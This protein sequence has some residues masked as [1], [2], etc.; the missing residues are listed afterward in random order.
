[1]KIQVASVTFGFFEQINHFAD[2]YH[3]YSAL[4]NS[5]LRKHL[6]ELS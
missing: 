3:P 5:F 2:L 1:M 4:L 6:N